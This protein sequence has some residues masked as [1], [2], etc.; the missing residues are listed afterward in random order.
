MFENMTFDYIL[1]RTLNNI[2]N[3]IDKRQGSVIYDAVAPCCMEIAKI[4]ES[5]DRVIKET[6]AV[7]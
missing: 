3:N 5:L 2:S 1:K 4:Y 6:F 7:I